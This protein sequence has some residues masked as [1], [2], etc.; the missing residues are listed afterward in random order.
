MVPVAVAV[1]EALVVVP[2]A[3]EV[4][5]AAAVPLDAAVESVPNEALCQFDSPR[6][7]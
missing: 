5:L 2:V 4:A 3:A 1:E 7:F 6:A